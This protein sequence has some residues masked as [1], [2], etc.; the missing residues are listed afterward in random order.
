MQNA[1]NKKFFYLHWPG[2][3]NSLL[4]QLIMFKNSYVIYL[5]AKLLA[6]IDCLADSDELQPQLFLNLW[7]IFSTSPYSLVTLSQNGNMQ[8]FCLSSNL[9][10][11]QKQTTTYP[12]L[13]LQYYSKY[14]YVLFIKASLNTWKI[15]TY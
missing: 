5:K 2:L 11:H 9:V 4:L 14:L 7:L 1:F 3:G 8:R 6:C 12:Y 15:I 10:H 13:F